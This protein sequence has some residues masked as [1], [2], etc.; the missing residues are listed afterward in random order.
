MTKLT[1]VNR[2]RLRIPLLSIVAFGTLVVLFITYNYYL[3]ASVSKDE[4]GDGTDDAYTTAGLK[5]FN[6]GTY[7]L[8]YTALFL[9]VVVIGT[10]GVFQYSNGDYSLPPFITEA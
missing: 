2:P 5:V 4:N 9:A 1:I 3:A 7:T 10:T 8:I 6:P